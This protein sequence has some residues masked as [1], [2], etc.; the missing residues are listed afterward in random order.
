MGLKN[1]HKYL[2]SRMEEMLVSVYSDHIKIYQGR[3]LVH[4]RGF[5]KHLKVLE[6]VFSSCQ[7]FN[8]K[9]DPEKSQLLFD[10][11]IYLGRPISK[12][13]IEIKP[14]QLAKIKSTEEP[15]DPS[16]VK[17]FL[18]RV[19]KYKDYVPDFETLAE[20]LRTLAKSNGSF[21]WTQKEKEAFETLKDELQFAGPKPLKKRS[22]RESQFIGR[23]GIF[24]PLES[25]SIGRI[26]VCQP[27]LDS[28][29]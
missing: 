25:Q 16:E 20:P 5:E 19:Q 13:G 12:D 7:Q 11:L 27:S 4:T 29:I 10:E 15:K 2:Q 18:R 24:Q 6:D 28:R 8:L 1:A 23:I 22:P 17:S 9:I 26:G 21:N 14:S 3:V